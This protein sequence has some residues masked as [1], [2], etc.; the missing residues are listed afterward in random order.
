MSAALTPKRPGV[1]A[2]S[3]SPRPT[4]ALLELLGIIEQLREPG[5]CPWDRAQTRLSLR[6]YLVEEVYELLE[7]IEQDQ[8]EAQCSETGDVLFLLLMMTRIASEEGDYDLEKVCA[9][10]VHKMRRRHPGI[11]RAA[12]GERAFDG[13]PESWEAA[14]AAERT[15]HHREA[16][17]LDGIPAAL[18]AL[19]RAHRAGEKVSRVG[20]DWPDVA[21]VRAKVDEELGELDRAMEAGDEA[22]IRHELGDLLLSAA[23]LARVLGVGPEEALREANLRFESRFRDLEELAGQRGLDLHATDLDQL[24]ALWQEVKRRRVAGAG[25][26]SAGA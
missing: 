10:I 5:G 4:P 15:A 26:G 18:P 23:N 11:L 22:A 20:F 12:E 6:P 24:E 1:Y 25:R 7:A 9:G 3:E 21:G 8:R 13:A 14:K 16:S 17:I 19:I 2:M